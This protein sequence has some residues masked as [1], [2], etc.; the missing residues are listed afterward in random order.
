M[1]FS[2]ICASFSASILL[3]CASQLVSAQSSSGLLI[4]PPGF[5]PLPVLSGN[6]QGPIE[7]GIVTGLNFSNIQGDILIGMRKNKELFFFFGIQSVATFKSKLA[8]DI[9]PLITSTA[10][11][12]DNTTTPPAT[13]LN[14]AFS[15]SGLTT[16]GVSGGLVDS[17]DPF[18]TGQ[19]NDSVNLGDPQPITN[20]W[21]PGFVNTN[22]LHGV[23]LIGSNTTD[24]V[25][26]ELANIQAILGDSIVEIHR[27]QGEARPGDEQGHEHFG[28]LDGI[29][30]PAVDGFSPT[31]FPGQ[32]EVP[33][34]TILFG[35]TGDP[36][37]VTWAQDGSFLAFRQLKQLV[38]EFN[39]FLADNAVFVTGVDTPAEGAALLGARMVGRWQSGAPIDLTPLKDDPSLGTNPNVNNN[40]T[41]VDAG[42]NS[43][44]P[45]AAHIRKTNPR[46]DLTGDINGFPTHHII[47]AGIPYGPEVTP[48][49]TAS[50]TTTI[51][52][53]LAFV[54][55][56]SSIPN[57]FRFLQQQWA[58]NPNFFAHTNFPVPGFD[59]I[60]GAN[61]GK[62]RNVQGLD[63]ANQT[64]NITLYTDF[65]ESRGGEYFF[66]PSLSA[67]LTT[68]TT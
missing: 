10:Q 52:R 27:L 13:L 64:R 46:A 32:A 56:Q 4:D 42:D 51:E 50:N 59:P 66:S 53:G 68:I 9:Y 26:A 31:V 44:C 18:A 65:V 17:S 21:I 3:G 33:A 34:S 1:R 39:K 49:E 11:L 35:Q 43:R 38:P 60:I 63:P 7:S 40:F 16:L 55:Y 47:R 2:S 36:N 61:E 30:Q 45:F 12:L 23:L 24:N 8:S 57:G 20:N 6:K 22:S 58:N 41:F 5:Q 67:I 29:G 25:N 15:Q 48:A 14:I 54:A 62:P 37:H 28:F 19:A